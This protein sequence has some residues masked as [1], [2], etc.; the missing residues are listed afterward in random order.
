MAVAVPDALVEGYED[1]IGELELPDPND[2]HVLAAAVTVR[3]YGDADNRGGIPAGGLARG[4]RAVSLSATPTGDG[5]WVFTSRGRVVRL[6]DAGFFGDVSAVAL[7]RPVIGS[8][9]TPSGKGSASSAAWATGPPRP[10]SS[11][12]LSGPDGHDS[13]G[14]TLRRRVFPVRLG[15]KQLGLEPESSQAA[16]LR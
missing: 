3:S 14:F 2:R 13:P 5:Y 16:R 11:R 10:L 4:E 9:A 8:I 1:L 7:N 15:T 6:R 12:S